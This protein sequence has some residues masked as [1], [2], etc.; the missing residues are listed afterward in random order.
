MRVLLVSSENPEGKW[1]RTALEECSYSVQF[2][3]ALPDAL[4]LAAE[5][6]IDAVIILV[7][8]GLAIE[9]L[10]ESINKLRRLLN[11][12]V[13]T[14]ISAQSTSRDRVLTLRAGADACFEK[15]YSFEE[16]RERINALRRITASANKGNGNPTVA[17]RTDPHR[18]EAVE[19]EKRVALSKLEYLIFEYLLRHANTPA[20]RVDLIRYAWPEEVDVEPASVNLVVTRLRRKL[21]SKLPLARID[22]VSRY[23]YKLTTPSA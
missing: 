5:D 6:Q 18:R 4:F 21:S 7:P 12:A 11:E 20:S 16:V 1:W 19:G 13:L 22:A 8:D 3:T 17:L 10:G 2:A 15:P 14:T 9:A 23:G